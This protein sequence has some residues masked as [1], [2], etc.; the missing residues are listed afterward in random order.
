MNAQIATHESNRCR[1]RFA[2]APSPAR[3]FNE[4]YTLWM[5]LLATAIVAA[6][7]GVSYLAYASLTSQVPAASV[8]TLGELW[9][10]AAP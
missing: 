6:G 8:E 2:G 5:A 4:F 9:D 3:R 1:C 7:F 10:G